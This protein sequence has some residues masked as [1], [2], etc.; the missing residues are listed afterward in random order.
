[1][2]TSENVGHKCP[3]YD[4]IIHLNHATSVGHPTCRTVIKK[5]APEG[6]FP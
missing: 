6:G 3:T 5:T 1:M 4:R 2:P